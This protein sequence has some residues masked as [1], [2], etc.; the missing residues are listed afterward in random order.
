MRISYLWLKSLVDFPLSPQELGE[1]LTMAGLEVENI[2]SV[3]PQLEGVYVGYV[4]EVQTHPNADKLHICRVDL[5]KEIREVVCGAPNVAPGQKIAF[6]GA[7]SIL[8][9]G[10]LIESRPIRGVK[11][12]GMICSEWELGLSDDREG[13]MVLDPEAEIGLP[14]KE[15]IGPQDWALDL[16]ITLNRPDCLSHIG[17]AREI[18]AILGLPFQPLSYRAVENGPP[19]GELTKIS[20]EEP[21]LCPRY[22]ARVIQGVKIAPSPPWLQRRL[23]AVGLRAINNVVDVTNYVMLEIGHPM[24]A[25]DF[26][27]LS[28]QKINVRRAGSAEIFR[29]LDGT[30][31]R[32]DER[33]LLICD[34]AGG[35]ALAGVMGGENSEITGSTRGLLLESAY[36]DPIN[37]RR[38]SRILGLST[39]SSRRFER[40]ADPEATIRSLDMAAALIL[41][42]AG[43]VVAQ[44]ISDVYPKPLIPTRIDLRPRR[45]QAI[46]GADIPP[47]NIKKYLEQLGCRVE[48]GEPLQVEP[49]AF[50]PDLEREIDLIEEVARLYGYNQ[51]PSAQRANIP[52][53]FSF[54]S[55][56]TFQRKLRDLLIRLGF[57]QVMT[58]P[59]ISE[60]ESELPGYPPAVKLSNPA[61]EDMSSLCN[62]LLPGLLKVAAH[63]LNRGMEDLRIFEIDHFFAAP[64]SGL[65]EETVISGLMVGRLDS[66]RWNLAPEP[67]TFLDLKGIAMDLVGELSIDKFDFIYYIDG[68]GPCTADAAQL[69]CAGKKAGWF[70]Q[71]SPTIAVSFGID[72]PIFAFEFSVPILQEQAKDRMVYRHFS[73]FPPLQRDLAFTVD[74]T[75]A[76]GDMLQL[77]KES[78]GDSLW[79]CQ[80][81][82]VY[83]GPQVGENRKSLA[84]RLSFQS[85]E[86]TLTDE[87]ADEAIRAVVNAMDRKFGAK[88]RT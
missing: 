67:V 73:K 82:D 79:E 66:R 24:H 87:E 51:V 34:G 45:V 86:R 32:L 50:R 53:D 47:V 36:F 70:G 37:T 39:D 63:N 8:P 7:G 61:S 75:V 3:G 18:A 64:S 17:V 31:R 68:E 22:S 41:Q 76:A 74:E 57:T 69:V 62:G 80:L 2:L 65:C 5:G 35:V 25:F 10:M 19:I 56:E 55:S 6:I 43:G 16:E 77:I 52:L 12:E 78:S 15:L 60:K 83:R 29:T 21:E 20:V 58:S 11:S 33:M 9:N 13:I 59:L 72:A 48:D 81:F 46:I 42:T 38:T 23:E 88:L 49:P 30:E 44:G 84:F 85:A 27:R 71:I 26:D 1:V 28:G 54:S 14:L 40:G 4:Q